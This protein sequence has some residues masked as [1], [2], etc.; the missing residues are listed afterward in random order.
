MDLV[1]NDPLKA[2]VVRG[3]LAGRL[4]RLEEGMTT[5]VQQP[6]GF[7]GFKIFKKSQPD[8]ARKS[9]SGETGKVLVKKILEGSFASGG[10]LVNLTGR[11]ISFLGHGLQKQAILGHTGKEVIGGRLF[12]IGAEREAALNELI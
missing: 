8:V 12:K 4:K 11:A 9:G 3:S 1:L 5:L 6:H 2:A 7:A 10:Q